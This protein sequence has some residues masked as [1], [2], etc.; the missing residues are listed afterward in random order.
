MS[1]GMTLASFH[2]AGIVPSFKDRL[3]SRV[4]DGV[5]SIAT[6]LKSLTGIWSGSPALDGSRFW[7]HDDT[8]FSCKVM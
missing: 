2:T 5:I 8:S 1:T 3:K 4:R 7:R 6:A